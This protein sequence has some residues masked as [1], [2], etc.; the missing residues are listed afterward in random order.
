MK[1]AVSTILIIAV[2]FIYTLFAA[3]SGESAQ[4]S[5]EKSEQ[6]TVAAEEKVTYGLNEDV[7]AKTSSGEVRI[8]ITGVQETSSRNE[9]S[10]IKADRVILILYEYENIS[11]S[12]DVM[13]SDLNFKVYDKDNNS[14]ESY[15]ATEQKYGDAVGT[16]RKSSAVVAY[17]LNNENNYVELEYYAN[18]F[19]SSSDCT[20]VLEW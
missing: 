20:F 5:T 3:A 17:A 16:G 7:Y 13:I 11:Y 14:L 12:E 1:K 19:N 8:K 10:D 15:P 18:I 2:I 4:T 6:T 9:F